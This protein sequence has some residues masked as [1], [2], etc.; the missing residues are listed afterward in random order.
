M[1]PG[2]GIGDDDGEIDLRRFV[3]ALVERCHRQSV[4][5]EEL[6]SENEALRDEIRRLK[7]LPPRP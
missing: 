2:G 6:R 3:A 7:G 4:E 1:T 5:I